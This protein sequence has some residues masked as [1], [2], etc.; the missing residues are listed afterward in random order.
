M[1]PFFSALVMITHI[2]GDVNDKNF[3]IF[4]LNTV[5][6]CRT[7]LIIGYTILK[8]WSVEF[9][10]WS[11]ECGVWSLECGVWSVECGVRSF[12]ILTFVLINANMV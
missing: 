10:V 4:L 3:Q 8:V 1:H 5:R 9:G 11:V 12:C 2:G 7:L 6:I